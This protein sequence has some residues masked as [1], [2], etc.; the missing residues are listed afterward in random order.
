MTIDMGTFDPVSQKLYA[1]AMK[2]LPMGER[3]NWETPY[4]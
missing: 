2:K 1:I 3:W 4:S